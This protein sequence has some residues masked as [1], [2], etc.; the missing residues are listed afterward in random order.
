MT[1]K[2]LLHVG[3]D[4]ESLAKSLPDIAEAMIRLMASP[5]GDEVKKAA[6]QALSRSFSVDNVQINGCNFT[7]QVEPKRD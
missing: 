6:I 7:N 3:V 5:A 1:I 4:A 2:S